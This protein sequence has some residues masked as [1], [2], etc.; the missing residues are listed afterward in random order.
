MKFIIHRKIF[1]SML[2]IAATMLGYVSYKNLN[3]ELT[4]S[5]ELPFLI[6]QISSPIDVDPRYMENQGVIPVEGAV[7]TLEGVE[8][9]MTTV[10]Q[11]NG[12]IIIWYNQD[13]N[14]KYAYLKL[15]E[16]VNI[17]MGALPEDFNVNVVRVD[18][19]TAG[20]EFMRLEIRG[21]GGVDRVRNIVD[22]EIVIDFENL[23]GIASVNVAGGREKTV[24]VIFNEKACEAYGITSS[25]IRNSLRQNAQERVFVGQV[26]DQKQRFF[27]NVSAEYSDIIA[28]E[29]ILVGNS[30][31]VRLRDVAEVFFGVKE[32]T[33]YSRVNGLEAVT[34]TLVK[35]A[36]VNLIDLSH[37]TLKVIEK[38]NKDLEYQ[39]I[40]IIVQS[41][42]AET[43]EKSIDQIM[44]LALIGGFLAIILLWIFLRNIRLVST[45]ALAIPISIFTAF[46]LFY[47][48][49]ISINSLTLIGMTLAIGML[50]DNSIVVLENIYRLAS[51]RIKSEESVIRGTKEVR[52]AIIAATLT[53]ITVFVPFIFTQNFMIKIIGTAVGISIISTLLVSLAVALLLIPTITYYF[54][55][56]KN[57][58]RAPIFKKISL[59][60]RLVQVYMQILKTCMRYPARTIISAVLFFFMSLGISLLV[61]TNTLQEVDANEINVYMTMP[62]GATLETTDNLV[63]RIEEKLGDIAE[64]EDIISKILEDEATITVKLLEDYED[65]ADRSY[66]QIKNEIQEKL[67]EFR[68]SADIEYE[69]SSSGSG[70]GGGNRGGGGGG[71]AGM[72]RM[73]GIGSQSEKVVIKGQDFDKM[74]MIAED[75]EYYFEE[76]SSIDN[77]NLAISDNRPE[78][79]ITFDKQLLSQY[80]IALNS[81]LSELNAFPNEISSGSVLKQGT[82]EYDIII[83]SDRIDE[84]DEEENRDKTMEDLQRLMVA[85][86]TGS[87]HE[88]QNLGDIVYSR[89]LSEINRLNQ[90]KQIELTYQFIDE[91]NSAKSLLDL[92][93]DEIDELISELE[94][95]AGV[96][97]EVIHEENDFNEFYSLIIAALILI[98][99]ILAAV[100]E[101]LITPFVLLFAIP[102]AA[103]GS[104]LLLLFTG[105]SIMNANVFTG[106]IIL[107]G[108]VVNNGIIY[109][110]FS[111]NLQKQGYRQSRAL[112]MAGLARLRPIL[113]TTIT[114]IIA[115]LPLAMGKSEYT[116]SIG[117]P[118]A[119]TVIGGLSLSTLLTLIILPTL[120]TS[121]EGA[122]AWFKGLNWKNKLTQLILIAAAILLVY[123]YIEGLLWQLLCGFL[124]IVVIPGISYFTMTSLKQAKV[125]VI[126]PDEE[127]TIKI[128]NLVKIYD[129][130]SKFARDWKGGQKI[131]ER[132]GIAKDFKKFSDF[133]QM[134]WQLPLLGFIIFFVY[135]YLN[136][137]FWLLVLSVI[138]Y[139]Y[140]LGVISPITKY[141]KNKGEKR[142]KK[143]LIRIS[144]LM[145]KLI[146]W[147]FPLFSLILFQIRWENLGLVIVL[148]IIWYLSIIVYTSSNTLVKKKL[149]INRLKG[150]FAG[151]RRRWYGFVKMIPII[152]KRNNPFRALSS[153]SFNISTGMFGLLGPNGAGKTTLMRIICGILEQSYGKIFINGIDTQE[154]REELQGLIGYLPQEFGTYENMTAYEFLGYQAIMKNILDNKER[155]NIVNKVLSQ[156]HMEEHK[157]EK[158]SSYSG[159]MKQRIGIAQILLH[160][161]RILVVDE[162]TAGL[163]P[164]ERIRFRNLL[165]ELSRERVVIFSTHI[166]EDIASSCKKVAVLNRGEVKYLGEPIKMAK[167]AEGKVWQIEVHVS[168][169]E[170]IQKDLLIVGHMQDGDIIRIR[171]ISEKKPMDIATP[172]RPLLEDAYLQLLRQDKIT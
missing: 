169:F 160:L 145:K 8:E 125:K 31:S 29:N 6:V 103:T 45:I 157:N 81:V 165:V 44:N 26:F 104:V 105:N 88:L 132:L 3:V 72:Q 112:M 122:V 64:K 96:A 150:R 42:S 159:G 106:C 27:V 119:I 142:K 40:E 69:A 108:V 32:E 21:S 38:L 97:V 131:R 28:I 33:S 146:F 138:L 153:V 18:T 128:Q 127:I 99:M 114:T 168:K 41:N 70:G 139:F 116:G 86:S 30:G 39:D 151:I 48:Y 74:R 75:I 77:V 55:S 162:P 52:R 111:K 76:L 140:I 43:M 34:V 91:V 79:H 23:D 101:S 35:D 53:T 148:G 82:D 13:V 9:I 10:T 1:I 7:G 170:E 158:I 51:Q 163:D 5:A 36:Q 20:N 71:D 109:L 95:P 58:K 107:L 94:L 56:L 130:D 65:I 141:L 171:C 143:F 22:N 124:A 166:I 4:P 59:H 73:L 49:D 98:F 54:L 12:T 102:F 83:K 17:A 126:K 113:I 172:A 14:L 85:G 80:G 37:E 115:L 63:G 164:R 68:N 67:Y 50:L 121:L 66:P 87:S 118:F 134:I 60:N 25:Q 136:N 47:A 84:E 110:D 78:I 129:R 133:D 167:I 149:N 152:G 16:K 117:A 123:L 19:E 11:R 155:E 156:V 2:F 89:G 154:K 24:E 92:S 147:F 144:K 100:F 46:N 61:T 93:R 57:Q 90:E 137:N 120:N 15:Q 135:Y 62:G 161:P